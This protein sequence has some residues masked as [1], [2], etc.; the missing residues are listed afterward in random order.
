MRLI[1]CTQKLLK[2][3]SCPTVD[4]TLYTPASEGLGNWYA[5]FIR[6]DRRKC[7][8]FTNEKTLY[9][10]LIP[11]VK[12]ENLQNIVDEFLFNLNMNLQAEGFSIDIITKVML[13]YQ[14]IGFAKTA[15]KHVLGSMNELTFQYEY[16]IL[17]REGGIENARM[18]GVN[19]HINRTIMRG[20]KYL[21]P[22][23]ALHDLLLGARQ[24]RPK[25]STSEF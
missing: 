14:T 16:L 24:P 10:F 5:N 11:K 20:I 1:H 12:K 15:S 3:L 18:I 13:E 19:K 22:I 21:H 8:L 17:H 9:S 25:L 6:I 2:E 7:V 4:L 23:E